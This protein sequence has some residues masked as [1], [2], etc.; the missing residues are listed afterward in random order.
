[1]RL[2]LSAIILILLAGCAEQKIVR[3]H[4]L[5]ESLLQQVYVGE[6]SQQ[7]VLRVLG[8]PT[9]ISTFDN[10]VWYYIGQ[11]RT[12]DG[13][14]PPEIDAVEIHVLRFDENGVVKEVDYYDQSSVKFLSYNDSRTRTRGSELTITQQIFGNFGRFS[15]PGQQG[16][17]SDLL[18]R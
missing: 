12:K 13:F 17:A 9:T 2:L 3:G 14:L 6:S 18:G 11:R 16:G 8:T 4:L 5:R 10:G 1:M 7:D 15:T